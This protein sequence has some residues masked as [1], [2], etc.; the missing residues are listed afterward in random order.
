[1]LNYLNTFAGVSPTETLYDVRYALRLCLINGKRR[2]VVFILCLLGMYEEA[3]EVALGG[4][5]GT[6]GRQGRGRLDAE[7]AMAPSGP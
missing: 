2:S 5:A 3:I 6:G 7:E 1:M 4:C